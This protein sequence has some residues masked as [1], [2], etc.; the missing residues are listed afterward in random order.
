MSSGSV[1]QKRLETVTL[2][3]TNSHCDTKNREKKTARASDDSS[4]SQDEDK[5]QKKD[6]RMSMSLHVS[7]SALNY[8]EE[9]EEER[10]LVM[11]SQEKIMT[12]LCTERWR[13]RGGGGNALYYSFILQLFTF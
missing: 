4:S 3:D 1:V 9:E 5:K 7:A 2:K 10:S 13:R 6:K 11:A 12:A 8:N